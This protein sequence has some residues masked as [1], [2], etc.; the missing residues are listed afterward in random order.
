MSSVLSGSSVLFAAMIVFVIG[1]CLGSFINATAMRVVAGRK[2]WGSE[3]SVCDSCGKTLASK[4]LVPLF[5]FAFLLGRCRYCKS[6]I[7][8]RHFL[9]E[10]ACGAGLTALYLKFGVSMA[11]VISAVLFLFLLFNSLTDIE[12]QYIYDLTA[13]APGVVCLVLRIAGGWDAVLDGIIGAGVGFGVIFLIIVLSRGGMG[14]GDATLMLGCGAALGWKYSAIALYTGFMCGGAVIIPLFL[15]KKLKRK[16]AVPLGPFLAVGTYLTL[17]I[18]DV[19][20]R[21]FALY[22]NWPWLGF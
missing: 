2:W 21:R 11:F 12:S 15:M 10:I 19:V 7:K 1:A 14:W 3:R 16:D 9:A 5:S 22:S 20:L 18:G 6:A 17:F 8:P 4:D 13:I